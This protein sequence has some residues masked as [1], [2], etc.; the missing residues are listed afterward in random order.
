[1]P[2]ANMN[3]V[4][5]FEMPLPPMEEQRRI[6]AILD[7]AFVGLDRA[8]AHIETNL[9]DARDLLAVIIDK[10]FIDVSAS[11]EGL[12]LQNLCTSRGITYGVIKLGDHF[13][14]GIP[15]LRTSNV[16][17]LAFDLDGMKRIDPSLSQEYSRTILEGGELLV[18][19]RGTLGGVAVVPLSM[20]G[21]NVSREVAMVAIDSTHILPEYAAF[22]VATSKAICW[23]TGVV[24]GATYKGI[25]LAD[26]R[27]LV[28]PCPSLDEQKKLVRRLS[29]ALDTNRNLVRRNNDKL[30]DLEDLRQSLLQRAFAGEL[31]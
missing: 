31:T 5:R 6:V 29:V 26:L 3:E 12:E 30:T 8:C 15:C 17:S 25:N 24:T 2:R 28:V 10:E 11:A 13:P 16:R 22:F 21:W 14:D 18:N 20:R 4:M 23:L 7:D 1:M 19:V 27:K 9:K